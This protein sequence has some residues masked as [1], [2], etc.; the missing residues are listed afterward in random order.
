MKIAYFDCAFGAAGDM[1]VAACLDLGARQKESE[2]KLD[3]AYL[4]SQLAL[5]NLPP[6]TFSLSLN[7]VERC[8]IAAAK[9]E[10]ALLLED[11]PTQENTHAHEHEHGHSQIM[12]MLILM[13]SPMNGATAITIRVTGQGDHSLRFL[14]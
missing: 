12:L 1:L 9:F 10:V 4:L 2:D 3:L 13:M 11:S 8:S 14:S 6:Q 7:R 5:L